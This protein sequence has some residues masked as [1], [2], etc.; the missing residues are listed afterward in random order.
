MALFK[1]FKGQSGNLGQSSNG[2]NK[3]YDGYAYFTPDDGKFYIDI[4][5][6][7]SAITTGT[8]RNRVPLSAEKADLIKQ[9]NTTNSENYKILLSYSA[10]PQSGAI[11]KINYGTNL[12]YNPVTNKLKTGNIELTGELDVTGN[13][14][15]K[16][17]TTADSLIAGSLLVNGAATFIQSPTG[18]T[19]AAGDSSTKLATTE[20]VANAFTTNDIKVKQTAKTDN[21]NYK[22][23][24]TTSASPTSGNAAEAA[25]DTDITIN[26]NTNTITATNFAGTATKA[27]QD[28][29]GNVIT[30]T[31]LKLSGGTMTGPVT[32]LGNQSS[33][34]NDKG[35]IFTGGS[36][37]GENT[38]NQ[39]GLYSGGKFYL[40]PNSAS[41][42]SGKGIEIDNTFLIPTVTN[43]MSLG[44][45]THKWTTVYA[46]TF[47]G[48]ATTA[49]SASKLQNTAKI[50]DTNKPV[51]FTASGV[52]AAISYTIE[53][54]VPSG[55]VFTDTKVTAVGNHYTPSAD[56]NSQLT[57]SASGA[58]AAW[59]IDVVK[60][61]QLQRDAKG[62]VTGVT[63]TSGKIPA[64]PNTDTLVKQNASTTNA[65]YKLL[66]TTTASPT[67]GTA[68]EAN[69]GANLTYNPST[70]ILATGNLNLTGELDV[71]GNAYLR[72]ETTIDSLTAGS[73][74]VNGAAN[75]V[76]YPTAPTPASGDNS[77][78]VATTEFVTNSVA[79]LSGAMHFK[80][81]TI[82]AI[83]D[84]STTNP[85]SIGGS[86][87]TATAGDVVLREIST[88]NIFE[89]VW[90]GSAWEMLGR[91]TSFKVTQNAVPSPAANGNT[92]AFIDTISQDTNGNITVTKKNLDTS[93]TWSGTAAKAVADSSGN[94]IIDTYLTKTVGV[95]DVSWTGNTDKKIS[96]TINGVTS[97]I[98]QFEAGDNV[99]LT[100]T[101]NKLTIAAIEK[102]Y[103]V[104]VTLT[105][106]IEGISDKSHSEILTAVN[107]QKIP[108]V[109]ID[110]AG[111]KIV[112]SLLFANQN[113]ASFVYNDQISSSM[114]YAFLS[115]VN[116]VVTINWRGQ[117]VASDEL[118]SVAYDDIV[119]I[120]HGGTGNSDGYIR[121]GAKPALPIGTYA[122]AEGRMNLS[123]GEASH[124]EGE[125]NQAQ[126]YY[127]HVEGYKNIIYGRSGH[128]FGE[129][130]I[131]D[132]E[133][134]GPDLRSDYI[135]IVGNGTADDVR[136]NARTL[137]WDGNEVL[138][139]KLTVGTNPTD[140]MDVATKQYV[141]TVGTNYLPLTGGT[142][143]GVIQPNTTKAI[144]LGLNDKRWN[145]IYGNKLILGNYVSNVL[146][147]N[148]NP[149]GTLTEVLI[150]TNI[151]WTNQSMHKIHLYG[152]K[153][154]ETFIDM[155]I[156]WYNYGT[157]KFYQPSFLDKN[158]TNLFTN[159]KIFLY[160]YEEENPHIGI[161]LQSN[162]CMGLHL[163]VDYIHNQSQINAGGDWSSNWT[164]QLNTTTDTTLVPNATEAHVYTATRSY[165]Y[166]AQQ[167]IKDGSGNV[168]TSTYLTKTAGVTG[169][170]WDNTN[171]KLTKTINGTTSD[172]VTP[173]WANLK[174]NNAA[175][176]NTTPEVANIK[177]GN[178][179]ATAIG[180]KGVILQYDDTSE[181]LNF[182]FF[183]EE[184]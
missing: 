44:D 106:A 13:A 19:A 150:K 116:K 25:Y 88:G 147:I 112:A 65:N 132:R 131:A 164:Y 95:I 114:N 10:N 130:N 41:S 156:W 154:H 110:F 57:A 178:G 167:A 40:R 122:T 22:I 170:N 78:K 102:I 16:N 101:S 137:D 28:G 12:T 174:L 14:Y 36:R 118:G 51:Y 43:E 66:L 73:I 45:S 71:T 140:N 54:S 50:G 141:D 182:V 146:S 157:T 166:M 5:T 136:S 104:H 39:L 115:I 72:N 68:Y 134:K 181:V 4:A 165:I 105:N 162:N 99:A 77:T 139:G 126:G 47:N 168:I 2:T 107:E 53:T 163:K 62:H 31:Y 60:A 33:A 145:N 155:D 125:Q 58:T 55:A 81:T 124:V 111:S 64:N 153:Y 23:L 94:N 151:P 176:Y 49:T 184:R 119:P 121:T 171:K 183:A 61:V 160:D 172:I 75:F 92:T 173:Y 96:K 152:H 133:P 148:T 161:L 38:S 59:S 129:Y 52:P 20:F 63:V 179:T 8:N 86:N 74:L 56:T 127:S 149:S 18:P 98:I 82:T 67:T 69:Y 11:D 3:T 27:T 108:F 89:Y 135:E 180:T 37:I 26:P 90:T 175:S 46:T 169:V 17:E 70:N 9:Y 34:Y 30:S 103:P 142:M 1:I 21:V 29:N 128:V 80:G 7:N 15:L 84:G 97:D 93:G 91:D 48:N 123:Q 159:V 83:V 113:R 143:T 117:Y 109:Y 24:F 138:A 100:A 35:I 79:G 120:E 76:Q 158:N 32:F 6:S 177:I 42:S 144:D 87:Y 85:I